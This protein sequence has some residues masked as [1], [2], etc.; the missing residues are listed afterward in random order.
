MIIRPQIDSK[1]NGWNAVTVRAAFPVWERCKEV[2]EMRHAILVLNAALLWVAGHY[3]YISINLLNIGVLRG[4]FAQVQQSFLT[5]IYGRHFDCR[6]DLFGARFHFQKKSNEFYVEHV[7]VFTFITCFIHSK[8]HETSGFVSAL[9]FSGSISS[10][11]YS[12]VWIRL[13]MGHR[14][15]ESAS[16]HE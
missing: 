5:L 14:K 15:T 2:N 16:W 6:I 7:V 11:N 8:S 12:F 10:A 3:A 1:S 4:A 13:K 9:V